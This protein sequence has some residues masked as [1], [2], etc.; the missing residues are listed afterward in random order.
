MI[1][2]TERF[3]TDFGHSVLAG[4]MGLDP[5][6]LAKKDGNK[7]RR[8]SIEQETHAVASFQSLLSGFL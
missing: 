1:D 7:F 4:M 5:P 2:D 3:Q 8:M 6:Q